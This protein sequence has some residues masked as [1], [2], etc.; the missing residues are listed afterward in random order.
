MYVYSLSMEMVV[1]SEN[2]HYYSSCSDLNRYYIDLPVLTDHCTMLKTI[3]VHQYLLKI[4][5][6]IFSE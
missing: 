4:T 5:C 6:M 3:K 2:L 1:K